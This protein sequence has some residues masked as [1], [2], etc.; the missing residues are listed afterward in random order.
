MCIRDRYNY[1]P[2]DASYMDYYER[3]LINQIVASQSHDTTEDMH[4]GV[5][6]MLPIDPGQKKDFDSDYGGFTC[7]N[8]TGM[9]NHVKYQAAT[10]AGSGNNLYVNLY[11]PTT[12]NWEEKGIEIKQETT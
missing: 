6:Y 2:D 4:N 5:T 7:C 9:E 12:L 3:T 1:N 10:Y 8:G 11:M